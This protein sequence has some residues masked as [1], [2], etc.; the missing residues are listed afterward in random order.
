MYGTFVGWIFHRPRHNPIPGHAERNP[1]IIF[2]QLAEG[3]LTGIVAI[4][5]G[6]FTETG[7]G[8][9]G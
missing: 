9:L 2:D 8:S 6:G 5:G 3:H 1:G 4:R 7:I